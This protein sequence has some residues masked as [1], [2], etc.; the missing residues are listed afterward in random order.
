M[1]TTSWKNPESALELLLELPDHKRRNSYGSFQSYEYPELRERTLEAVATLPDEAER[2]AIFHNSIA[3]KVEAYADVRV[4]FDRMNFSRSDAVVPALNEILYRAFN[5]D[6][7]GLPKFF[8]L[9][10][11]SAPEA[12]HAHF[13]DRYGTKWLESDPGAATAWL[14]SRGLTTDDVADATASIQ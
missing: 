4:A 7:D 6:P 2:A 14:E 9:A 5:H 8:D 13:L 12:A 1:R 10:F 3:R 11:D